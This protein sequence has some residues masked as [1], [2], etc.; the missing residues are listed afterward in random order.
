[1]CTVF[2]SLKQKK[3]TDHLF[4]VVL[5]FF[6]ALIVFP[7]LNI[8]IYI[9][10]DI[11]VC[12]MLTK[13]LYCLC[14]RLMTNKNGSFMVAG[15]SNHTAGHQHG[16]RSC[17]VPG[18]PQTFQ[19]D[20]F[21]FTNVVFTPVITLLG[22]WSVLSNGSILIAILKGGIRI[23]PGFLLLC[24]LTLT[25]FLWGALVTPVYLK[26]R[27]KEIVNGYFCANRDDWQD[28]LTVASFFLCLFGTVGSLAVISLDR[29]LAIAKAMWYKASVKPWHARLVCIGVWLLS[30]SI[31]TAK[32]TRVVP[33][34]A[35]EGVEAGYVIICSCFTI[36]AQVL[37]LYVLHKHNSL[38]AQIAGSGA[39]PGAGNNPANITAAIERKLTVTTSWVVGE[40]VLILIPCAIVVII[41]KITDIPF[42]MLM[43]P[44]FFPISSLVSSVN[45]VLYHQKNP[46]LRQGVSRLLKCQ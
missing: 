42:S 45:P 33:R 34:D 18:I 44:L 43:E 17:F 35:I 41:S 10:K 37:T 20:Y 40:L 23:R 15:I 22:I 39:T 12:F 24:S 27:F 13:L 2:T 30:S 11:T 29:Y 8:I 1:M 9:G 4:L 28:P 6:Q 5:D 3:C 16:G 21:Y 46:Q 38:V 25:D 26:F 36:I 31:I 32:I 7:Y 19:R 14:H